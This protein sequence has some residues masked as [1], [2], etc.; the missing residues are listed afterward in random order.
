VTVAVLGFAFIGMGLE[1]VFNP[2]STTVARPRA[3]ARLA[4][5]RGATGNQP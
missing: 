3:Y 1:P 4:F 2:R 5:R